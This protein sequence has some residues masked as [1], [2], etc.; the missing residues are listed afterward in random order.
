VH[1]TLFVD[2]EGCQLSPNKIYIGHTDEPTKSPT[3]TNEKTRDFLN[4]V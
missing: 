3:S 4:R 2:V 1:R